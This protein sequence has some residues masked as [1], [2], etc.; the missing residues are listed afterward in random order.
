MSAMTVHWIA[1]ALAAMAFGT[2]A[3][4]SWIPRASRGVLVASLGAGLV[5]QVVSA[6]AR[7]SVTGHPPIF[8]TFENTIAASW[9]VATVVIWRMVR[10]RSDEDPVLTRLLLAW[11]VALLGYGLFF[12]RTPYPLT[13]SERSLFIDVHVLFA[14]MAFAMLLTAS[15][16]GVV[17]VLPGSGDDRPLLDETTIRGLGLGFALLTAMLAVG[18]IYSY[19]LFGDWYRWELVGASAMAAWLGYGASLHAHLM[20]GWRGRRIAWCAIAMLPLLLVVFWSWSLF[21]STYH[22]F[23][24]AVIKAG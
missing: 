6:G 20:F 3:A 9:A 19:I 10:L 14:W 24:I 21:S 4:C 16:A 8:G 18:S 5:L 12:P 11:V 17:R 7:W 15:M 13:I 1:Y 22:F 2:A 23:D